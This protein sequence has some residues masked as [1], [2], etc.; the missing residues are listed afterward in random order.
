ME[1]DTV[2]VF[3]MSTAAFPSLKE[4]GEA[5]R[6]SGISSILLSNH[7]LITT[8]IDTGRGVVINISATLHYG[9]TWFQAHASAAKAAIDSLTRSLGLEWGEYNIRVA[10]IAPGPIAETPGMTKL[11]PGDN[12]VRKR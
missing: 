6:L 7:W 2:G 4:S 10:G 8:P 5:W 12:E 1:I 3:N 11:A 9:A